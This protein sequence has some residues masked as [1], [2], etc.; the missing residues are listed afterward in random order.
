[1]AA[2]DECLKTIYNRIK[3][4]SEMEE[5]IE[6][7]NNYT[8]HY[9]C[10][11]P[12]IS[13]KEWDD[14]YF[15]LKELEIEEKFVLGNSPTQKISYEAVS[16]LNKVKHNHL[17]LSL[18]KT[19][20]LN[21]IKSFVGN[22]EYLMMLKMDG[23]TCS[24]RY[25]HGM[26]V[27]AETRGDGKIGEDITHNAKVIS[28]IPQKVPYIGE[29][30]ID[31][32]IICKY[33]D[34]E[35]FAETYKNPRN[36]A[37]GS[38][39]LLDPK[40]CS[41]RN[42]TFIAWD[43]I[44]GFKDFT[45]LSSKFEIL[46]EMGFKVVP[47][48]LD[49]DNDNLSI[50]EIV[51]ALKQAA[52]KLYYPIDGIVFK[53]NDIEYSKSLGQTEHH[54]KNAMAYK[55]YDEEVETTLISIDYDVSRMGVLTPVA[56]FKPIEIEGT[57]VSRASLHNMSV[58]WETLGR[59]P[60]MDQPI[61]VI[62]SNQIIPQIT[63]AIKN[64]EP[65]DHVLPNID[66]VCCPVCGNVCEIKYS[67]AGVA[68]LYCTN[69]TC[70]GKLANQLVHF[71]D[72]KKG[73]DIKGI[74]N[75][76]S[77]KLIDFGWITCLSDLYKLHEHRKEWINKAGYGSTSVD[78]ILRAIDNSRKCKLSQFI[79][80]LGIPLIGTSAAN[81]INK[82]CNTWEEFKEC[83]KHNWSDLDGFGPEMESALWNFDYTEADKIAELLD[84]I[85]L[86]VQSNDANNKVAADLTFVITGRLSRKRDDIISDIE[87]AG[88]KVT[89]SV[90]SKTSYLVCNDK[91]STTGKSASAKKNGVPIITEEELMKLLFENS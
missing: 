62:K 48:Y 31:G 14:L 70:E 20:D 2:V 43:V 10:G 34:F 49:T 5:L 58:M 53:F 61:W 37:S 68:S 50:E 8:K 30:I 15:R 6:K 11:N 40:E 75:M 55:F 54:F 63:R 72:R 52:S 56:V 74:S 88:G 47:T 4:K 60:D 26:L 12:L 9:D 22:N 41:N 57:I 83:N 82:I 46:K 42:L 7:L 59:Y 45:C 73:M 32:E 77:T 66:I 81:E 24:L 80:A 71:C 29:L 33:D 86:E 67:D 69:P 21:T 91:N 84:F 25:N 18:D 65:H 23:L 76:T 51:D 1:M 79:S 28:S 44:E 64:N 36:F 16:Q 78:N 3:I 17:M 85:P 13:D 35:P 19:K 89:S 90:S 87:K 39:R 27:S 38:I